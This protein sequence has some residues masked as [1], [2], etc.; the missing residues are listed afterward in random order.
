MGEVRWERVLGGRGF[1]GSPQKQPPKIP[2]RDLGGDPPNIFFKGLQVVLL[3]S[4]DLA[5][6]AV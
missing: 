6:S 2:P 5:W 3:K 4:P 1:S